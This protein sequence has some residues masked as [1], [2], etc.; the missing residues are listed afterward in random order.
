MLTT[1]LLLTSLAAKPA[2]PLQC[3]PPAGGQ[4]AKSASTDSRLDSLAREFDLLLR[5]LEAKGVDFAKEKRRLALEDS[6]FSIPANPGLVLGS[7]MAKHTLS[8]FTDPE[9]PY[10]TR[11]YPQLDA[12]L[13]AYPNL[14]VAVHLFPLSFHPRAMP[15]SRAYWAAAQ[16]GKF[17]AYF[18][19]L[20]ANGS[21]DL[22]DDAL[23]KAATT[24]GL[25]LPRFRIDWES[26]AS[27][28]AVLKDQA[29]GETVGVQGTPSL[30]VN[31][32]STRDPDEALSRL[33]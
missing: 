32:K 29:L 22:S 8:I 1:L 16:Q 31:G 2:A 18:H 7:P 28:Q 10:C 9:C 11:I 13:A 15:S 12:W 19:A 23:L 3:L 20:H 30:Y 27:R 26:E 4:A 25:D 17:S 24:S 5:I 33:K 6:V 21:K 14:K